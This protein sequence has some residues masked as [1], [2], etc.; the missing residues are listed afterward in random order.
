ML[1]RHPVRFRRIAI[2]LLVAAPAVAG[3]VSGSAALTGKSRLGVRG[4]GADRATFSA[5]VLVQDDGT[6]IAQS[7]QVFGGTYAPTGR[8]GRTLAL[9]FDAASEAGFIASIE[10]D[11][12]TVC[13]SPPATVTSS[14]RKVMALV[15]NRKL[16]KAKLV[17][18]YAVTGNAGGRSGTATYR[19]I[20]RGPWTP[21]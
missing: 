11:V 21:G 16:T 13:E 18:K 19:L 20:G 1:F 7:D 2:A 3:A 17:V 9:S 10:E 8:T 15:L 14:R 5:S 4:C 12:A 6:W